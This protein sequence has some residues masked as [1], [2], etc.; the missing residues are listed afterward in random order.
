MPGS[1]EIANLSKELGGI[2]ERLRALEEWKAIVESHWSMQKKWQP[3]KSESGG[4]TEE[5]NLEDTPLAKVLDGPPTIGA[6]ATRRREKPKARADLDALTW[7]RAK[8]QTL[9]KSSPPRNTKAALTARRSE[10]SRKEPDIDA[11][12]RKVAPRTRGRAKVVNDNWSKAD[13]EV[14]AQICIER[15]RESIKKMTAT[16]LE[17]QL[18]LHRD[19]GDEAVPRKSKLRLVAEKRE[20]VLAALRRM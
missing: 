2:S 6:T 19:R 7:S 20:A 8:V 12:D 1:E 9:V 5:P 10:K 18:K 13:L 14:S 3:M 17:A 16:E 11:K 4:P 15:N